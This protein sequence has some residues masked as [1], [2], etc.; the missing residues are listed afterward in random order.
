[1]HAAIGENATDFPKGTFILPN[2]ANELRYG[3]PYSQS[4]MSESPWITI[5]CFSHNLTGSRFRTKTPEE[6]SAASS[7]YN[8]LVLSQVSQRAAD[9]RWKVEKEILRILSP[10]KACLLARRHTKP[11]RKMNVAALIA[12]YRIEEPRVG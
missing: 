5:R 10:R 4:C 1:M 9:C 8:S 3:P 7:A 2:H 12:E 6:T 11:Y